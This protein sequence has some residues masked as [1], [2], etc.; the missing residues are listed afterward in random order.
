MV[1]GR[2]GSGKSSLVHA[3]LV[4]ALRRQRDRFWNVVTLQ[5]GSE[6]IEALAQL[7]SRQVC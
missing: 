6:P 7:E 2:S 1:V 4:P 3:G 5:P